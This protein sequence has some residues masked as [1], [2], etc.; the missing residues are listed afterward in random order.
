MCSP[1]SSNQI[2]EDS[3]LKKGSFAALNTRLGRQ[4]LINSSLINVIDLKIYQNNIFDNI[5]ER[6]SL[7][8][9]PRMSS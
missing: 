5:K 7:V 9:N 1:G 3:S 8:V 2:K 4:N 6:K